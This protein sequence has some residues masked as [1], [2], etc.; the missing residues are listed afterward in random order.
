MMYPFSASDTCTLL[1]PLSFLWELSSCAFPVPC[2]SN[3][4]RLRAI[5]QRFCSAGHPRPESIAR[6]KNR[7]VMSSDVSPN[8]CFASFFRWNRSRPS[9]WI[10]L[11]PARASFLPRI[12]STRIKAT[13]MRTKGP[14]GVTGGR[15]GRAW[16]DWRRSSY[17]GSLRPCPSRR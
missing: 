8:F 7:L 11:A 12:D 1:Y 4:R 6:S 9:C 17:R 16:R 3:T 13:R 14:M 15:G 5:G 10:R 2:L